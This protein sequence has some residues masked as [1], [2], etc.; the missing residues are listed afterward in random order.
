MSDRFAAPISAGDIRK[1]SNALVQSAVRSFRFLVISKILSWVFPISDACLWYSTARDLIFWKRSLSSGFTTL[2]I[3]TS[4]SL[5]TAANASFKPPEPLSSSDEFFDSL[6]S[7]TASSI[8]RK[9]T[10]PSR[11]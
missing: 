6:I 9:A 11:V 3:A 1:A 7:R 8:P 5:V 4:S 10:L 2:P